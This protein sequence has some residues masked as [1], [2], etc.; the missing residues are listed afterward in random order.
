MPRSNHAFFIPSLS[1]SLPVSRSLALTRAIL[2][3]ARG[4]NRDARCGEA[5][6]VECEID[7]RLNRA[8]FC[9]AQ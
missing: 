6:T 3:P 4:G 1:L 9:G 5:S 7:R 2:S 8:F